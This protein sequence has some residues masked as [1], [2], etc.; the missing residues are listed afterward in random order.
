MA[1]KYGIAFKLYQIA[2]AIKEMK[3]ALLIHPDQV[4]G[5]QPFFSIELNKCFLVGFRAFPI[6]LHYVGAI[7]NQL[8]HFIYR[9]KLGAIHIDNGSG[10][11]G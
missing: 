11:T 4:T 10:D 7:E 6:T 1:G 5:A 8:P 3:V 9:H 2:L